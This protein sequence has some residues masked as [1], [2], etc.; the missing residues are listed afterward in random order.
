MI[1]RIALAAIV[2][3]AVASAAASAARAPSLPAPV[4]R[5]VAV[6]ANGKVYVL[7][8]HDAAGGSVTSVEVFD[9]GGG[10]AGEAGS[11]VY[12][13]HGAA[14]GLTF[15]DDDFRRQIQR[16]TGI[17]PAWAAE[18]FDDLEGD[19]RQSVARIKA[20][21]FIPNKEH[22]RGFIYDVETGHLTEVA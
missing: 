19:V 16:D 10:V 22:V 8:G 15:K 12:P 7:G 20:S 3:A 9:P 1:R 17:K 2:A 11:L 14:R 6:A 18:A 4:Y 5:T 21:P 13:T